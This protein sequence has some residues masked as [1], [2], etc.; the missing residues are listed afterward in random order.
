MTSNR[1]DNP[2]SSNDAFAAGMILFAAALVA[3][4]G[5]VL[6]GALSLS[7]LVTHGTTGLHGLPA[8]LVGGPALVK[9]IAAH[10]SH[11]WIGYPGLAPKLYPSFGLFWTAAVIVAIGPG[12]VV[13]ALAVTLGRFFGHTPKERHSHGEAAWATRRDL[14]KGVTLR[15]PSR[16]KP[17]GIVLGFLGRWRVVQS[18]PEDNVAVFGVGR[19]G[20]TSQLVI[21]TLLSWRGGV[22]A[23]STKNELVKLTGHHR[24]QFGRVAVFA[25]LESDPSWIAREGLECVTWNPLLALASPGAAAELADV[26]TA[27]GQRPG[28]SAHWYQSAATLLTG[29]FGIEAEKLRAGGG[30]G[31]L[32]AVLSVLNTTK[33]EGY[34]GLSMAAEN[35]TYRELVAALGATPEREAGSI[36]STARSSLSL[37]NDERVSAATRAAGTEGT[38]LDVRDLV[39]DGGTLYLVAPV[40][41]AERCRPLFS[42]LLQAI[43][44]AATARAQASRSGVLNPRLLLALD[45]IANFARIPRLAS[46]VSTGPGQ[47][48]QLLLCFQDLAQLEAGYGKEAARS[49]FNNCRCR[50]LLPGQG[51]LETLEAFSR[52]LGKTTTIYQAPSWSPEGRQGWAEQRTSTL[53]AAP[54][55]LR[56]MD[57]PLL[58]AGQAKPARLRGRGWWRVRVW[59]RLVNGGGLTNHPSPLFPEDGA[60]KD[61][62]RGVRAWRP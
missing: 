2:S 5:L 6:Y 53:L 32:R 22:V 1:Y 7:V 48:I 19:S 15:L 29:L 39:R 55:V 43:L 62:P 36:I 10:G 34:A 60:A 9:S 31:D 17:N 14:R 49:I 21:P 18:N 41:E 50:V 58:I 44:R 28:E 11:P 13:V 57:D 51:D 24:R 8:P 37:W 20:K 12:T 52:S 61:G 47:G 27:D 25:P 46:Y 4:V 30:G 59:R 38:G 35:P 33:H 16:L 42:A 45:E 56:E 23:T 26:F 40:E 3:A 54:E